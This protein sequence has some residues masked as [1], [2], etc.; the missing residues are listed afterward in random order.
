MKTYNKTTFFISVAFIIFVSGLSYAEEFDKSS[1]E[2]E[3]KIKELEA[4]IEELKTT[5]VEQRKEIKRLRLLCRKAGVSP[6]GSILE[7]DK[8]KDLTY[9]VLNEDV[10]DAPIKTQI[11]LNILISG[12]VTEDGLRTLLNQLYSSLK[13]RNGFK[14]HK[15]PTN[16]YIYAYHSKEQYKSGM[17]LWAGMLDLSYGDKTPKITIDK[18]YLAAIKA[19]PE[20]KFGLTEAQRMQIFS[21]LVKAED[22][23][24]NAA[25]N[26][27][28]ND[29]LKQID[30]ERQQ[31]EANKEKL[32]KKY[33][34]S[35]EDFD[36]IKIEGINKKW[37]MP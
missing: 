35:E 14:Y 37:P 2:Q 32:R 3:K 23:A 12:N 28:P 36:K 9:E 1:V 15:N 5:V 6:D 16:I 18:E 24:M 25:I 26:K 17:G 22:E 19:G 33:H 8:Q 7:K 13:K 21:E 29:S 4:Q 11:E 10:Y 34:L 27:Y 30:Y 31:A 20:K